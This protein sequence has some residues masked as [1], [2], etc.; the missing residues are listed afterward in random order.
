MADVFQLPFL[1]NSDEINKAAIAHGSEIRTL[2]ERSILTQASSRV[3]WWMPLGQTVLLSNGISVSDPERIAGKTVRTFG[4]VSEALVSQCGGNPK[5]ISAVEQSSAY[6][7]HDV[8]VGMTGIST[9]IGRNLWRSMNTIT[10][11]NHASIQF[12]VVINEKYWQGLS[13][14]QR[15]ILTDAARIADAESQAI[16]ADIEVS[17][18]KKLAE[19]NGIKIVNLTNDELRNWRICSSDLLEWFL[20]KAGPSGEEVMRAYGRINSALADKS[21]APGK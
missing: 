1:F 5:N 12:V 3:M 19:G 13:A 6:E 8:D 10:R 15:A 2:I 18:Y 20:Q 14:E 9:I 16:D 21:R 7:K 11:T 4:P 17:G